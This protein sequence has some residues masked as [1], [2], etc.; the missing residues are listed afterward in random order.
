M[1]LTPNV[2]RATCI[3]LLG[4][5]LCGMAAA[6]RRIPRP[7]QA[8]P[9]SKAYRDST[10]PVN[11]RVASLLAQMTLEEKVAQVR[12]IWP[13]LEKES[14]PKWTDLTTPSLK[15]I[16]E[17]KDGIGHVS[18]PRGKRTPRESALYANAIQTYL[19]KN[20][21]LG[22][23]AIIHDEI[24]HGHMK[25]GST[26]FPQPLAMGSSWDP[27]LV[28]EVFT[29]AAHEA[30]ARG[31][32]H[33]L[34]P[35]MDLAREPRWGRTE[36]SYGEDPYLTARM[37]TATVRGLQ[38][39]SGVIDGNHV[40]ATGKHFAGHGQPEGG[41]NT[42]PIN[43]GERQ[44]RENHL[45]TFQAAVQDAHL[46]SIMPA[47]HEIDGIPSHA[48]PFLLQKVLRQ[49]WGFQGVVVSDYFAVNDLDDRHHV[50]AG[51]AQAAILAITTGVDIEL[52][53][54]KC[55]ATLA[56]SVRGGKLPESVL[57]T[58]VGRV[59]R[60]K[61]MLGLFENFYVDPDAAER[62]VHT[63]AAQDLALRMA[64]ESITLLRNEHN[65]LPLDRA[66]LKQIAVIGPNANRAHYGGYTDA[67]ATPG[68]SILDGVRRKLEGSATVAYAE[69]CKITR[70]GGVWWA[71]HADL[72]DPADDQ[73]LIAEAAQVAANSDA[74][75]L[76]LGG[77]ED[78]NKEGWADNHLGDRDSIELLGRQ[79]DLVKA[80]L[81]TGKPTIVF[82]QNSGPLAIPYIAE[83]VPA[84][85][86]GFYLGEQ[87][88]TAAADVLFGDFNPSGKLPV[89]FPRSTGQLP[90]Y[91]DHKPSARR[92]YL[93]TSKEPVFPFGHGLSYTTFTYRNLK[94]S[95]ESVANGQTVTVSVDVSNTGTRAGAEVAQMYIRD[96]VSSVTRP[97][98]ELKDFA[99]VFLQPGET[100]SI[101]FSL[102][103]DKLA[104]YNREMKFVIEPGM[105]DIMVGGSSARV[106]TVTLNVTP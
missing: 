59:L 56:D 101:T 106:Q 10:L 96:R 31:F 98:M 9:D 17:M 45:R 83:N 80:I 73:R 85:L 82:L 22:I 77:N 100:R 91:Y 94:L 69:G 46:Q 51:C 30:R 16:A 75:V 89:S 32:Q 86:E 79:N 48:N 28:Q 36:E 87:G 70:Q 3:A 25:A 66:K 61:F 18:N 24:L 26:V 58:A 105:F 64:R 11:L 4:T 68:V 6:P 99:R 84:V 72:S 67:D 88:G 49:E 7:N 53:D 104:F 71:D 35:N 2:F 78:T 95:Q 38:G 27:A 76:V 90:D 19:A 14:D 29:T 92:G 40:I 34:G 41:T 33:V 54:G 12:A 23:P 39:E 37:V 97:V 63:A 21:R 20:T 15:E 62:V 1:H 81:A 43:M 74:V 57:D 102:T 93:F 103:P 5:S 60:T 55:Y 42:A 47:Y 65:V 52:P 50:V 8:A 13:P 44:L